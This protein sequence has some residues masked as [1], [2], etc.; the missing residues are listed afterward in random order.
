[1]VFGINVEAVTA[2]FDKS[3]Y[4][5]FAWSGEGKLRERVYGENLKLACD[6]A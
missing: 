5:N 4:Y 1:M 3:F 6:T 2:K